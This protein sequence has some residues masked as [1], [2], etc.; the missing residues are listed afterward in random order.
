VLVADGQCWVVMR[1]YVLNNLNR[2]DSLDTKFF[3][4]HRM[5]TALTGA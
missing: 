1:G 3:I 4:K 2:R 5:I